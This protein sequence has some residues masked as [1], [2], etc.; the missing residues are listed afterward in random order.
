L[1]LCLQNKV[2]GSWSRENTDTKRTS[3]SVNIKT[4]HS[5]A[6]VM[7][8]NSV[9]AGDR[10]IKTKSD[11]VYRRAARGGG[12]GGGGGESERERE[13]EGERETA[14]SFVNPSHSAADRGCQHMRRVCR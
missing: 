13:R 8:S 11:P 3:I 2:R 1:E 5:S 7:S 10:A 12:G 4:F 14:I 6:L 9:C